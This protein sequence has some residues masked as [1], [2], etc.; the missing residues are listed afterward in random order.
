MIETDG[1]EFNESFTA[2][3]PD[4]LAG[5]D[6]LLVTLKAWQVSNAVKNLSVILPSS[7]PIL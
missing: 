4:F 2:N 5:S 6:L 3:D 7:S 1:S